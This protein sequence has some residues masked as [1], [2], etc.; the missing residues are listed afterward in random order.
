MECLLRKATRSVS[1]S[2]YDLDIRFLQRLRK[3]LKSGTCR[4]EQ[5]RL[6]F[7]LVAMEGRLSHSENRILNL[8]RAAV[9]IQGVKS[10]SLAVEKKVLRIA[11]TEDG[12]LKAAVSDQ[13]IKEVVAWL[14]QVSMV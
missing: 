13:I 11:T 4:Q 9:D 14:I 10:L 6:L 2:P 5:E 1:Y 7:E 8:F 12:R 3:I